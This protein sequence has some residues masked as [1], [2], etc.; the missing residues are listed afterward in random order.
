MTRSAAADDGCTSRIWWAAADHFDKSAL[1][2]FHQST[3]QIHLVLWQDTVVTA[4]LNHQSV[5][6]CSKME[7]P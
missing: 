5:L 4:P 7:L 1:C 2:L 6:V 3:D